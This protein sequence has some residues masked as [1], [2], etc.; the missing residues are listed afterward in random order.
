MLPYSKT[1]LRP[2]DACCHMPRRLKTWKDSDQMTEKTRDIASYGFL[3]A[4][5]LILGFVEA[6]IPAFF[7]VPGMKLGLTNIVVLL[8]LYKWSEK[9]AVLVNLTRILL[10]A[11]LFGTGMSFFYSLAGGILSTAVMILLKRT[12]K[13]RIQMVSAAGGVSHNVGQILTAMLFLQTTSLAWYLAIL[14]FTGIV[15]GLVIGMLG[16]LLCEK[17]PSRMPGEG[18]TA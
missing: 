4:A 14:W 1:L 5:A 6:Q 16:A 3:T 11:V 17:L 12:G 15:C 2:A 8:A 7:A 18:G 9:S 10:A 13:F